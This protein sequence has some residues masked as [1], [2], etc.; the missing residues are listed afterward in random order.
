MQRQRHLPAG[1][2]AAALAL[3][4]LLG[5]AGSSSGGDAQPAAPTGVV[6]MSVSDASTEDWAV[7]GVK[8]LGITLT[9]QNGGTPVTIMTAPAI[10]PVLN[11]VQ[12]DNLSDLLGNAQV[13]VGTYTKATLTLAA[14]PG[15]VTLTAANSPSANF[16]SD[17][18]VA[19]ATVPKG[20]I[21]I[22][23]AQSGTV[24][25]TL[26]LAKPLV[27]S[28]AQTAHLDLEFILSH[29]A[30]LV[31]H[32]QTGGADTIWTVNFN[33][34]V[35]HNLVTAP[36][37]MVLRHAYG[38]V[39]QVAAG[40][41]SLTMLR[42]FPTFPIATP[43][44]TATATPQLLQ[45]SADPVN[46]TLFHDVDAGTTT[47]ITNFS[48]VAATLPGKYLRCALRFQ[49]GGLAAARI[50]ASTRFN[51]VWLSPEGHVTGVI[52]GTSSTPYQISVESENSAPTAVI[53]NNE[54]QFFF[55]TPANPQADAQ[56]LVTGTGILDAENLV[57]GFKVHVSYVNPLATPLLADSVDIETASYSGYLS[58][59]T[60]AGFT[61]TRTFA[62]AIGNYTATLSFIPST[63]ANGNDASGNPVLGYQWWYLT[64][65]ALA[66]TSA[67]AVTDLGH[68]VAGDVTFGGPVKV[69]GSSIAI[70]ADPS[71][72]NW[73][74]RSTVVEPVRLPKGLVSTAFASN[75]TG[76]TFAMT[77]KGALPAVTVELSA[78]TL[79][80][81]ID[82]GG[83]IYTL[84]PVSAA[85]LPGVLTTGTTVLVY[86]VPQL[87]G[88]IM[89]YVLY[90]YTAAAL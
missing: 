14:S 79:V 21:Q 9:P 58:G 30:F 73:A 67:T 84:T 72:S 25:V 23:G 81:Q 27:V 4:A 90:S 33:G 83:G 36:E 44:E 64:E 62:S 28:A 35:R 22:K 89:A 78:S 16:L 53:I 15:D 74:A 46:G 60:S 39:T 11:L 63:T 19:G 42:D 66:D 31:D 56:P 5:C 3:L 40:G 70:P 68:I 69:W 76:G 38:T 12:L 26:T 52:L 13:P 86:G 88:T 29:P 41:A 20:D 57:R 80:Y 32:P 7:I 77:D 43:E 61:D 37:Q 34:T 10:P 17:G 51:S 75:G 82:L 50:W 18:G 45:I 85:G 59:V 47:S 87:D 49:N 55:R 54:T 2:A 48:T 8:L 24:S 1:L 6:A 71:L 65:P